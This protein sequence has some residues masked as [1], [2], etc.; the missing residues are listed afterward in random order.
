MAGIDERLTS[1]D[2]YYYDG[3]TAPSTATITGTVLRTEKE[4][5]ASGVEARVEAATAVSFPDTTSL[6]IV[7]QHSDTEGGTYT[8]LQTIY[9]VTASGGAETFAAGD[10]IAKTTIP[11]GAKAWTRLSVTA[12]GAATGTIDGFVAYIPR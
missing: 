6:T 4:G 2:G 3:V 12:S 1:F 10:L 11:V 7:L 9:D 5:M 8:D